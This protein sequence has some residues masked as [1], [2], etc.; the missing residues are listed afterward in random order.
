MNAVSEQGIYYWSH[1]PLGAGFSQEASSHLWRSRMDCCAFR[2]SDGEG[3]AP[4]CW[5]AMAAFRSLGQR[6]H[7]YGGA[8]HRPHHL[9][10]ERTMRLSASVATL[11]AAG[12][13]ALAGSQAETLKPRTPIHQEPRQGESPTTAEATDP[14]DPPSGTSWF[15]PVF[16]PLTG[17]SQP[18]QRATFQ[19]L[20]DADVNGDGK[21]DYFAYPVNPDLI[22][23]GTG[24]PGCLLQKSDFVAD[25][26][27]FTETFACVGT[28]API[29]AAVTQSH[30]TVTNAYVDT[31]AW[32]DIDGD[33]DLD[34]IVI[35][36]LFTPDNP[37]RF[38]QFT[39]WLENIGYEKSPPPIAADLNRDGAVNGDDLGLLL[40]AWGTNS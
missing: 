39:G 16:R 19:P 34:L 21:I 5:I 24:V 31:A 25:G 26:T 17:C 12:S 30:P 14:C 38:T 36:L 15:A 2:P 27:N 29:I 22:N 1:K 4:Q 9:G 35:V 6:I 10:D 33:G 40:A 37:D 13:L 18:Y 32:R 23:S 28:K 20:S 3:K 8:W 7:R 11:L